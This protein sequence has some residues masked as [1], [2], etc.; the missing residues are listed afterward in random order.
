MRG[1]ATGDTL[2]RAGVPDGW[3]VADKSGAAAYGTRND[4][5][6][7]EVPGRDPVV[8]AVFSDRG[9]ADA[10]YDDALVAEAARLALQHLF[11]T[12]AG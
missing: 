7:V 6:V 2:V 4:I 8:M 11:P 5:A 9:T 1:N 12:S 3:R 10:E